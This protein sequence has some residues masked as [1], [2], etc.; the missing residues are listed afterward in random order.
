MRTLT[1]D[2]RSVLR[3]AGGAALALPFLEAMLPRRLAAA[4]APPRRYVVCFAGMSLGRDNT[5]KLS[6]IVPDRIGADYDLKVP[7]APLA[8]VKREVTVVSG[9]DLPIG[10]AGGRIAE[11]H[12]SSL[13]PLL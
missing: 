12:K 10:G 5:G 1:L 3:G 2:R 4:P 13:S 6:D 9:L 11:F 7:L 8:D